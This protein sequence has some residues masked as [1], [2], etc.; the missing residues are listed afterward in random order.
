[1]GLITSVTRIAIEL[2]AGNI[3][4]LFCLPQLAQLLQTGDLA[5]PFD[6]IGLPELIHSRTLTQISIAGIVHRKG[7]IANLYALLTNGSTHTGTNGVNLS[8]GTHISTQIDPTG[9]SRFV[10][11]G[12][13]VDGRCRRLRIINHGYGKAIPLSGDIGVDA[14]LIIAVSGGEA[15]EET[16]GSGNTEFH[17]H[18]VISC[19]VGRQI[20]IDILECYFRSRHLLPGIELDDVFA[21]RC[22]YGHQRK[23]C[24]KEQ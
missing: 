13:H 11:S 12:S 7:H 22:A 2:L 6:Q 20:G 23:E 18:I 14:H 4:I 3:L 21:S 16:L 9:I 17:H 24:N 8:H 15:Q 5:R 19:P 1:M 10:V